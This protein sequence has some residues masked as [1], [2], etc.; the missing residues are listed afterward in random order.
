MILQLMSSHTKAAL[1]ENATQCGPNTRVLAR[2][3]KQLLS[4]TCQEAQ[5]AGG[6]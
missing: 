1:L 4:S 5:K 3:R 2:P 6:K